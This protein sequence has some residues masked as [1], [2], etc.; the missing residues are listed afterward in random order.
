MADFP[1]SRDEQIAIRDGNKRNADIRA[2]LKEI[3]RQHRIILLVD[4][5]LD[6]IDREFT[7]EVRGQ[8]AILQH[9]P[10]TLVSV[11]L[12]PLSG[13]FLPTSQI[14]ALEQGKTGT[15]GCQMYLLNK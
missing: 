7:E 12:Y 8:M 11:F 2:L 9:H 15:F 5:H 10:D 14:A 1:L 6:V 13:Y 3:K 4:S